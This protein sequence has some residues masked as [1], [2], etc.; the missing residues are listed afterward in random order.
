MFKKADF[1]LLAALVVIGIAA[2][3]VLA[4]G[5]STA[6]KGGEVILNKNGHE[7]ARYAID[8]DRSILVDE[9]GGV[10]EY[11][12]DNEILFE[13]SSYDDGT[14]S[15]EMPRDYNIIRIRGGKVSVIKADC[16]S[17]VCVD[18]K[19]ISRTGE[20]II[21]LPHKLVVEIISADGG[22]DYDTLAK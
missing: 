16:R 22:S 3:A 10:T 1:I 2:S 20:S 14:V 9:V 6:G 12:A 15:E 7:I 8:E 13:G 19:A 17:Q 4:H 5:K 11:P 18:H 21:C